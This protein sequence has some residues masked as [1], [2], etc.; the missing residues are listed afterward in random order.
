MSKDYAIEK[1]EIELQDQRTFAYIYH[2]SDG[3]PVRELITG[4]SRIPVGKTICIKAD[5]RAV[6][7]QSMQAEKAMVE[8]CEVATPVHRLMT[9]P[10]KLEMKV[11]GEHRPWV[12]YPDMSLY[13]AVNFADMLDEGVPFGLAVADWRPIYGNAHTVPLIIEVK[14]DEDTRLDDADYLLKLDLASKVYNRIGWRFRTV[15]KSR[16]IDIPMMEKS[17]RG[18]MLD[19]DTSVLP[20]DIDAVRSALPMQ[21]YPSNLRTVTRALGGGARGRAK[22]AA[23]HVRR[24]I[25][26]DLTHDLAPDT[27]VR[28][29]EDG[30]VIF[31][32][33]GAYPW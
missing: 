26:I 1:R 3:G 27:P 21:S 31:E 18:I 5:M 30:G 9:Q 19:H 22:A 23:L 11:I 28:L 25:S 6:P 33:E 8:M 16:D 7:W 10:H 13:V 24:V 12:F 4:R 17:I 2:R 15:L 32:R 29:L 14:D 20:S